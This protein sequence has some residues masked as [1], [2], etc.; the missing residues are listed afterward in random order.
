MKSPARANRYLTLP[1]VE[2][3]APPAP[4]PEA[5]APKKIS[6][7]KT[8]KARRSDPKTGVVEQVQHI[9]PPVVTKL[10]ISQMPAGGL[11]PDASPQ[12]VIWSHHSA[13]MTEER[14]ALF[15][16]ELAKHGIVGL[17]AKVASPHSIR[18]ARTSFEVERKKDPEF[19][20]AFDEAL[21]HAKEV[22]QHE[23]HRRAVEGWEE[24]V[25]QRGECVGH[26]RRFSDRLLELQA[27]ARLPDIYR[28]H[29]RVDQVSINV[30]ASDLDVLGSLS[31][32]S[33]DDLRRI[34]E[35]EGMKHETGDAT[36]DSD[37]S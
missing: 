31:K 33:R 28:E 36:A 37:V 23:I 13:P 19:G 15:L 8:K 32:E 11:D 5:P 25:Y 20:K 14:K 21:A 29:T 35:R 9:R 16:S 34:F 1:R 12:R 6:L 17:A 27:K 7:P 3:E 10:P 4:T 18:G 30:S 24:P 2:D 26:V 22:I